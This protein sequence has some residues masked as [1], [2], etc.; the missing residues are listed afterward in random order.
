M[1]AGLQYFGGRVYKYNICS[2]FICDRHVFCIVICNS[3][4]VSSQF[5]QLGV[6]STLGGILNIPHY[7]YIDI[8]IDYFM[9]EEALWQA[10]KQ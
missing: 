2:M 6:I 10:G 1:T 8:Y 4:K 3:L 7:K 9:D 5:Y